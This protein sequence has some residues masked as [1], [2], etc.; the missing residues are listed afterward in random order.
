MTKIERQK[1]LKTDTELFLTRD[2][3]WSLGSKI[4]NCGTITFTYTMIIPN[5]QEQHF[6]LRSFKQVSKQAKLKDLQQLPKKF[7]F[8]CCKLVKTAAKEN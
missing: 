3:D 7:L 4:T 6:S 8:G 5:A 1:N 2:S